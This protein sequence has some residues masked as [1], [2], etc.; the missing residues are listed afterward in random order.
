MP[1]Q[2]LKSEQPSAVD[3]LTRIA[4]LVR[5]VR[6]LFGDR[7]YN[8]MLRG[9]DGDSDDLVWATGMTEEEARIRARMLRRKLWQIAGPSN[10]SMADRDAA[11]QRIEAEG[12]MP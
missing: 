4:R 11:E 9:Y 6:A 2:A 3:A 10:Y 1:K 5:I 7:T 8:V 12:L